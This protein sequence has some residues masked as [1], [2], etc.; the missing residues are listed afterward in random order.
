MNSLR[1]YCALL[2]DLLEYY[3]NCGVD[4]S[5]TVIV[6]KISERSARTDLAL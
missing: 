1:S 5:V 2:L 3:A 4:L 6:M